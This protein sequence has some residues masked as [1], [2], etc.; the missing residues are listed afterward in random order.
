MCWKQSVSLSMTHRLQ[1]R[2]NQLRG[3][4]LPD[5]DHAVP[6][7]NGN[8]WKEAVL[9]GRLPGRKISRREFH[10]H[11]SGTG[12]FQHGIADSPE[13]IIVG[14]RI[15]P[16]LFTPFFYGKSAGFLRTDGRIPFFQTLLW[17]YPL[18]AIPP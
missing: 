11:Q 17:C 18:H 10:F 7:G 13:I 3:S 2:R 6:Q 1:N 14:V 15:D 8:L 16:V 5:A 12:R 4:S 9:Y